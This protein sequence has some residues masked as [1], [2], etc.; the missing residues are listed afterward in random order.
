MLAAQDKSII[1]METTNESEVTSKI[2]WLGT[3]AYSL[4]EEEKRR[5]A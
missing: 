3:G 2:Y 5:A 1:V 4:V